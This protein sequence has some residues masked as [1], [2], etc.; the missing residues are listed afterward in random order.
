MQT[1][2]RLAV[3]AL[4]LLTVLCYLGTF[5]NHFVDFDD[6]RYVTQNDAV[7]QGL[8]WDGIVYAF[9]TTKTGNWIPLTW[10]SL[11]LD[12]SLFGDNASAFHGVNLLFHVI[13]VLLF[14]KVLTLI[15]GTVA[16]SFVAAALFGLHPLHV[17]SVAWMSERKDVLST[18][19]LLLAFITYVRY[20]HVPSVKRFAIV[21]L[22]LSLG[23][24]SKPML[25]TLPVLLL[26]AD[27]FLLNRC[28]GLPFKGVIGSAQQRSFVSLCLE[29]VPLLCVI[30]AMSAITI[31]AQKSDLAVV[32]LI[33]HPIPARVANAI[34]SYAWYLQ[35]TFLPTQLCIFYPLEYGEI[36]LGR[37]LLSAGILCT[38]TAGVVMQVRQRPYLMFSWAWFVISLLPV[39]GLMQVGGQAR[40]DRFSYVPH[41]GLFIGLIWMASEIAAKLKWKGHVQWG[42]AG[43]TL[44]IMGIL[45]IQQVETWRNSVA[46]WTHA[47]RITTRN[48][49]AKFH[50]GLE[51]LRQ[52]DWPAARDLAQQSLQI[53]PYN[54]DALA[55]VGKSYLQEQKW[56]YAQAAFQHALEMDPQ[57][58]DSLIGFAAVAHGK[59]RFLDAERFLQLAFELNPRDSFIQMQLGLLYAEAG[60]IDSA[61]QQMQGVITRAPWNAMAWKSAGQLLARMSQF[62]EAIYHLEQA[63]SL[64]PDDPEPLNTLRVIYQ[65]RGEFELAEQYSAAASR[66]AGEGISSK[67]VILQTSAV[68][69]AK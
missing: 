45:S 55:L 58:R 39:I 53:R 47:D 69:H 26:L 59:K 13:N 38:I 65:K 2:S 11:E 7:L 41:L 27:L 37:T 31:F 40:A 34:C 12:I 6:D 67:G 16:Q 51:Q 68:R 19:F 22:M 61:L 9:T 17:E 62:D 33:T 30:A 54:T 14:Y 42:L 24:L 63:A 28:A 36:D 49:K 3:S 48:W 25:V 64:T 66:L 4:V 1:S 50:L 60:R 56:D 52:Q 44:M 21:L 5:R 15:G 35:K 32:D 46:L 8:S 23:L 43:V 57:H 29:K 18:M 10:L 20:T